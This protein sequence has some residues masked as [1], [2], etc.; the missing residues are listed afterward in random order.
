ML[1]KFLLGSALLVGSIVT[2]QTASAY[3]CYGPRAAGFGGYG[4][5]FG[6]GYRAPIAAYR[7]PVAPVYRGY[8]GFNPYRS[9]FRGVDVYRSGYRSGFGY[10]GY[11]RGYGR[12]FGRSGFGI[13]IGF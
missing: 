1:K 5:G 6:Y 7:V 2:A 3:D 4:G 9:G 10:P 11:G 8:G 13:G 12:N